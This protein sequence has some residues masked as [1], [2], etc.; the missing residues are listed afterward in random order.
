MLELLHETTSLNPITTSTWALVYPFCHSEILLNKALFGKNM[1]R[2]LLDICQFSF[3]GMSPTVSFPLYSKCWVL[4]C[5]SPVQLFATP[6]TTAH[7]ALLSLGYSGQE[8]WSGLPY[9]PPG[10]LPN[11]GIEFT[12][13]TSPALAGEFFTIS[14]TSK[15]T[16]M[17]V[18]KY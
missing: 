12:S 3:P 17:I 14:T 16:L 2:H 8:Y 1:F 9:L 4:S 11:P 15:G 13:L 10:D 7:Q 5:F 6:W 18:S